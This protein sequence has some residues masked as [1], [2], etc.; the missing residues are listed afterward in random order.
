MHS[1]SK[2]N[3]ARPGLG[4]WWV[5]PRANPAARLRLFCFPYAGGGASMFRDW[6]GEL[7]GDVEVWCAAL[8][9]RGARLREAPVNSITRLLPP[10]ADA[11]LPYLDRPFALFGHSMGALIAFELARHL[12][13]EQAPSPSH[14]FVSGRRAPQLGRISQAVHELPRQEL[15][16]E[17]R[18]LNGTPEAVLRSEELLTAL[19][20]T[21][22]ADLAACEQYVCRSDLP[23]A[24]AISAY[25]GSADPDVAREDLEAWGAQTSCGCSTQQFAG[26]HFFLLHGARRE[27]FAAMAAMLRAL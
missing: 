15:I 8:P 24:V 3:V 11:M 13:R 26:D 6:P 9:G 17:L 10:L 25:G 22:R 12:R 5:L 21:L 4:A 2:Q 18:R 27:M 14:L 7:P 16:R 23:L 20:P 19:L 1:N